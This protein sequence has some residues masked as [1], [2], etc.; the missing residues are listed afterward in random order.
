M[1]G[2]KISTCKKWPVWRGC[3]N[4]TQCRYSDP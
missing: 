4:Q 2:G 3:G 1:T